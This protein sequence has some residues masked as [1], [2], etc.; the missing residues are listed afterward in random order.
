[1]VH[2]RCADGHRARTLAHLHFFESAVRFFLED[3]FAPVIGHVDEGR[4][5]LHQRI[6]VVV[7]GTDGLTLERGKDLEGDKGVFRLMYVV[8]DFHS[9]V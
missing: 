1:M 4:L 8:Y 9:G 5:E 2:D 7:D 6:Q 3:M